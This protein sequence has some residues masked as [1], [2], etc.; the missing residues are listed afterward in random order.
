[1]GAWMWECVVFG[2]VVRVISNRYESCISKKRDRITI[3][4]EGAAIVGDLLY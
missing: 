4:K 3:K 1:M 2:V